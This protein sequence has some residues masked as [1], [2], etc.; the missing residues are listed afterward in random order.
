LRE[1]VAVSRRNVAEQHSRLEQEL[2]EERVA[3]LRRISETLAGLID[4]LNALRLR[5]GDVHWSDRSPEV[6]QY[7]ELRRRA[8]RY[9]WYLEVQREA[10]GLRHHQ[11]LDEHYRIPGAI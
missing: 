9:R 11:G 8:V 1:N 6:A 10:L 2:T 7:R 3:A 4:Q 5:I